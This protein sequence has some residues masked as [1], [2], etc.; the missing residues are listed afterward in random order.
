MSIVYDD[1]GAAGGTYYGDLDTIQA[2]VATVLSGLAIASQQGTLTLVSGADLL[3]QAFVAFPGTVSTSGGADI[4]AA[5]TGLEA[6]ASLGILTAVGG[7][8]TGATLTGQQFVVAQGD[9]SSVYPQVLIEGQGST[10]GQ[11]I[12]GTTGGHELAGQEI[13]VTQGSIAA[14]AGGA[15]SIGLGGLVAAM[16]QGQF[17]VVGGSEI[18]EA[19]VGQEL[20]VGQGAI[21]ATAGG[22]IAVLTGQEFAANIGTLAILGARPGIKALTGQA[23]SARQGLIGAAADRKPAARFQVRFSQRRIVAQFIQRY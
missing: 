2:D 1:L 13:A 23:I 12:V 10:M 21:V 15:A 20:T 3:G 18:E 8:D 11:G 4:A 17:T 16:Q 14:T 7:G 5:L 19:L 6:T 22:A 9:I